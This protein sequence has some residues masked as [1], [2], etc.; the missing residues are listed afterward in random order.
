MKGATVTEAEPLRVV[1]REF[2]EFYRG[3]YPEVARALSLSLGDAALGVEAADEAMTRAY[4]RWSAVRDYRNAPGWVYRVGINWARS[5]L[6]KLRREH[7]GVFTDRPYE[8][9]TGTE[10]ALDRAL[11]EMPVRQRAVL[12][13]RYYLDWSIEDI[14]DALGIPKGTVK[15][16]LHRGLE[17]LERRLEVRR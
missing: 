13:L 10:P 3:Y 2:D 4:Q 6:R 7:I 12:V 15:S 11:A 9:P 17:Q 14:A 16:R 8:D 5:W 1:P